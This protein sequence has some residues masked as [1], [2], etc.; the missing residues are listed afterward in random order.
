M[1]R[2]YINYQLPALGIPVRVGNHTYMW[3]EQPSNVSNEI[4][5]KIKE[6]I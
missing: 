4:D 3:Q 6:E 5:L 2:V 1:H